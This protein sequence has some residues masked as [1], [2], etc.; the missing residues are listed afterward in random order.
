[1]EKVIK[2]YKAIMLFFSILWRE[3]DTV[4]VK[5]GK[6]VTLRIDWAT[7]WKVSKIVWID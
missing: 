6:F 1:M 3:W 2:Y 7:A 4:E 5:E